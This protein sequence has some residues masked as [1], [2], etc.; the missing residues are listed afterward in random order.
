MPRRQAIESAPEELRLSLVTPDDPVPPRRARTSESEPRG[1]QTREIT[2]DSGV[3]RSPAAR[4]AHVTASDDG[5]EEVEVSVH[6][7]HC[8]GA[9]LIDVA[10]EDAFITALSLLGAERPEPAAELTALA[11]NRADTDRDAPVRLAPDT[12]FGDPSL[13][14][15]ERLGER[16]LLALKNLR[17]SAIMH[18]APPS[19]SERDSVAELA[20]LFMQQPGAVAFVLDDGQRPI[21]SIAPGELLQAMSSLPPGAPPP[22]LDRILRRDVFSV[23]EEAPLSQLYQLFTAEGARVVA[24]I[25]DRGKL[26]GTITPCDLLRALT[27]RI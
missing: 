24:V 27:E 1:G 17:A 2:D 18:A 26:V 20:A 21:G 7:P 23:R 15:S 22:S 5:L 13:E 16:L 4:I 12:R 9:V 14:P 6:C 3:F 25:G 8:Q 10:H 11:P 19:V